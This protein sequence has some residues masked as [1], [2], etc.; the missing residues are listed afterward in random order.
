MRYD[1][2]V[3]AY[4]GCDASIAERLLRGEPFRKSANNYDWLSEMQRA[5]DHPPA[6]SPRSQGATSIIK[7]PSRQLGDST[8]LSAARLVIDWDQPST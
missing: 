2:T 5:R 7:A 6:E 1:R 4:H 3:I 8:R